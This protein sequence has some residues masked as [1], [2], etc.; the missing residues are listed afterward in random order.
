MAVP[1]TSWC[2]ESRRNGRMRPP[3]RPP[4]KCDSRPPAV[5]ASWHVACTGAAAMPSP[6]LRP[7]LAF[8]AVVAISLLAGCNSGRYHAGSYPHV[9][10]NAANWTPEESVL[11]GFGIVSTADVMAANAAESAN[12]NANER[13]NDGALV[14]PLPPSSRG[15]TPSSDDAVPAFDQIR[16]RSALAAV[17]LA[18]CRQQ[19]LP[20]GHGHANVTVRPDGTISSVVTDAPRDIS[21][22]GAA[23]VRERLGATVLP[24]YRGAPIVVGTTWFVR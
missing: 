15:K 23:C 7:A 14:A 17:D 10:Y 8:L 18:A 22:S 2:C 6:L 19:G 1:F 3:R 21:P 13:S 12:K 5:C 11:L 24:P 9:S 20:Q 16:A 4:P